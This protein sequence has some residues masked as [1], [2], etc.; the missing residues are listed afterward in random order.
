M[1]R[2]RRFPAERY[3]D[4]LEEQMDSTAAQIVAVKHRGR[5]CLGPG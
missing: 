3:A 4:L 2:A 1:P 5:A